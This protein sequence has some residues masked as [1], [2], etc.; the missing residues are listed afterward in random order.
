[1]TS[2]DFCYWLQGSFEIN[3]V[4]NFDSAQT[5]MIKKHMKLVFEYDK[6]PSKFVNWLEGYLQAS[7]DILTPADC[8]KIGERLGEEFQHVIDPQ[9]GD[10]KVQ[11]D[12][13]VIHNPS[14]VRPPNED[15][16]IYRC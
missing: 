10:E 1:M 5:D 6:T 13:N 8:K 4:K 14:F 3:G 9:Y 11:S 12:L 2:R 16:T 15:G 7:N